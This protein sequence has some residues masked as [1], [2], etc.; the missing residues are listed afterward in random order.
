MA[1]NL[2]GSPMKRNFGVGAS[3]VKQKKLTK[4]EQKTADYARI[5]KAAKDLK[6]INKKRY[7]KYE[8][9]TQFSSDSTQNVIQGEFDSQYDWD[10]NNLTVTEF[11]KKYS[12]D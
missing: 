11:N 5:E 7:N 2:K 10:K 4:E 8:R 6:K 3:P 12:N 9:Q 1:F